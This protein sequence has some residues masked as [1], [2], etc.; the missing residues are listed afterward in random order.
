MKIQIQIPNDSCVPEIDTWLVANVGY[1]NF[2]E[3]FGVLVAR[4]YR[5]FEFAR[6]EDAT[7]FALKFL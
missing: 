2:K 5:T 1:G 6:E 7:M 4:P 3:W